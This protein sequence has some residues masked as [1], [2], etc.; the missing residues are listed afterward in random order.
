LGKTDNSGS[1]EY[2]YNFFQHCLSAGFDEAIKRLSSFIYD[3]V[4]Q[5]DVFSFLDINSHI[6]LIVPKRGIEQSYIKRVVEELGKESENLGYSINHDNLELSVQPPEDSFSS[7]LE[8]PGFMHTVPIYAKSGDKSFLSFINLSAGEKISLE[9]DSLELLTS[10]AG[11]LSTLRE[12]EE[13]EK[14]ERE[15][16]EH[17]ALF[18]T[19]TGVLNRRSFYQTLPMDMARSKK[20]G[21]PLSLILLDIDEF[22]QINDTL[23]HA[24]GD[25]VLK[26]VTMKY[27]DML[28]QDETIYRIGG[29]EFAV[30]L[31]KGKIE[32]FSSIQD[33]LKEISWLRTPRVSMSGGL[34]EITPDFNI[35]VDEAVQ[36]ADKALY[37]AKGSGKN[38]IMFSDVDMVP[39]ASELES[40]LTLIPARIN[41]SLRQ[42]VTERLVELYDSISFD[43]QDM[44]NNVEAIVRI[45]VKIGEEMELTEKQMDS[46]RVGAM[47][48]EIG[49][50]FIPD[51]VVSK[52]G[53]YSPEEVEKLKNHPLLASRIIKNFPILTDVLPTVIYHHEWINGQGFPFGLAGGSIPLEPR[54]LTVS[55]AYHWMKS[56][57]KH[58]FLFRTDSSLTDI[59]QGRG[60]KYDSVVV[61]VLLGLVEKL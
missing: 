15:S 33:I 32:A 17:I 57:N 36:R 10:I 18:D 56:E 20:L 16:F 22:K 31:K 4:P 38:Q 54:I 12:R 50:A 8:M 14:T 43:G 39:E 19:L 52:Q 2:V 5:I 23:G 53:A 27:K 58:E 47:L 61:D 28:K 9:S 1:S 49:F 25:M 3:I 41:T 40:E 29:D 42:V 55:C 6:C 45:A 48:H 34:V 46:L 51:V 7:E 44:K 59:I 13:R 30:V 24:F 11:F 21:K 35:T 26:E 60:T 37:F